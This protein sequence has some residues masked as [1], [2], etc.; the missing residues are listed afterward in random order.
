M[1]PV[2]N[3]R[4]DCLKSDVTNYLHSQLKSI[5]PG[6]DLLVA[7][8]LPYVGAA[9][10]E[11]MGIVDCL[12]DWR[13]RGFNKLISWQYA[14]FLYKLAHMCVRN[15]VNDAATDRLFLLNKALNGLDLHPN[16]ELPKNFFLS[17][18]N[19][20][21]FARASYSDY[22][23]F[24]QGIT[25]GRKGDERPVMEEYLVMYP[26]SM[27]IGNCYVRKNTVLAPGVRLIDT[28]TPGN[29]YV[30]EDGNGRVRFQDVY[31]IHA[32]RFFDINSQL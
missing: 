13:E 20:A 31:E 24:H 7:E 32:A 1:C 9:I 28:N 11:T 27:I 10:I 29:C 6:D 4:L 30:F 25:V 17:H 21:V 15:G 5:F 14:T 19:S 18:T 3:D 26:A 8:V 12:V 16:I 23:V 2:P 22:C